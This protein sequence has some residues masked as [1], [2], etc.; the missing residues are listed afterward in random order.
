MLTWDQWDLNWNV[1]LNGFLKMSCASKSL[2][3][4]ESPSGKGKG[5]S[6]MDGI[7]HL[8]LFTEITQRRMDLCCW[9]N[10]KWDLR[11]QV[12]SRKQRLRGNGFWISPLLEI[13][14]HGAGVRDEGR[15][16]RKEGVPCKGTTHRAQMTAWP[17]ATPEKL[18]ETCLRTIHLGEREIQIYPPALISGWRFAP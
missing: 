4:L 6:H 12:F 11:K 16:A 14:T 18:F 3:N 13:A 9:W 8:S 15:E 2:Q 17:Y 5:N 7:V 10:G 1:W